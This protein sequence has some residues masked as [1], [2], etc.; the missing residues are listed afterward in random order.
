MAS[1]MKAA[2][3]QLDTLILCFDTVAG[4]ITKSEHSMTEDKNR[5]VDICH[6]WF[7]RNLIPAELTPKDISRFAGNLYTLINKNGKGKTREL[8]EK[9]NKLVQD[10]KRNDFLMS[11]SLFQYITALLF[12]S[13]I[14]EDKASDYVFPIFEEVLDMFPS[15]ATVNHIFDF[16]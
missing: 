13:G 11:I 16:D 15:L 12:E 3:E 5:I 7:K 1:Q 2:V 6:T 9:M 8:I 4:E 10:K 14:I